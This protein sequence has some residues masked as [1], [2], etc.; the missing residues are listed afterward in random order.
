MGCQF[1]FCSPSSEGC[2]KENRTRS[3]RLALRKWN[4]KIT[5]R[6]VKAGSVRVGA[7]G[8]ERGPHPTVG[9]GWAMPPRQQPKSMT[10]QVPVGRRRI[11]N[12]SGKRLSPRSRAAREGRRGGGGRAMDT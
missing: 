11:G 9:R 8:G 4:D 3:H 10:I 6:R 2:A 1:R 7:R 12:K 5:C